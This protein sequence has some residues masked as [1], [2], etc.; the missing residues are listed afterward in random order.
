[1]TGDIASRFVLISSRS[2]RG[3]AFFSRQVLLVEMFSLS[4]EA[5]V[6][7]SRPSIDVTF[8]SAADSYTHRTVGIILTGAN[9]D[10]ADVPR[11]AARCGDHRVDLARQSHRPTG[12]SAPLRGHHPSSRGDVDAPH[13]DRVHVARH[14]LSRAPDPA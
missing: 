8:S 4:T 7:F 2:R 10:G 3:E 6:R 5:P 13:G 14:P 9:A 12:E 1:M 11:A